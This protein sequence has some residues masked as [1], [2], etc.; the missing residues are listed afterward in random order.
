MDYLQSASGD[1]L[2]DVEHI[3]TELLDHEESIQWIVGDVLNFTGTK[4]KTLEHFEKIT[5]MGHSALRSY[6]RTCRMWNA[7]TRW[8]LLAEYPHL[9]F[10]ILKEL[11]SIA[12]HEPE[13][14][15]SIAKRAG[16]DMMTIAELR[17][18]IAVDVK[19]NEETGRK[20]KVAAFDVCP[21]AF[22]RG[23]VLLVPIEIKLDPDTEYH[24]VV[25]RRTR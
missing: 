12:R 18:Y 7:D 1:I 19:G 22:A 5:R 15:L 4:R 10:S 13:L 11:N 3:L 25:Y 8:S 2:P 14:A 21:G 17:R 24:V 20:Q 16:N 23:L 6:A 9:N